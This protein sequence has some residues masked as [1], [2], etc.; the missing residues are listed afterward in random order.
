MLGRSFIHFFA[1]STFTQHK[2]K[3]AGLYSRL[4]LIPQLTLANPLH[5]A[6]GQRKR[7]AFYPTNS[8]AA[9]FL[10]KTGHKLNYLS[11]QKCHLC[12]D[13]NYDVNSVRDDH[14]CE[15]GGGGGKTK[16]LYKINLNKTNFFQHLSLNKLRSISRLIFFR[17]SSRIVLSCCWN[18]FGFRLEVK[19]PVG[20][21]KQGGGGPD[22]L[23]PPPV[24][25]TA[26]L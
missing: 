10:K 4:L 14:G 17:H 25:A 11:K 15:V 24:F 2:R 9:R 8:L 5:S 20:L 22:P 21:M 7:R 12:L 6:G 26:F 16:Y 3:L 18:N 1:V 19:I 23:G 13:I